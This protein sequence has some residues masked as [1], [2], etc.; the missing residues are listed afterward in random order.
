MAIRNQYTQLFECGY[1]Q[2]IAFHKDKT[3]HGT[4]KSLKQGRFEEKE[5]DPSET[6]N[7]L[8]INEHFNGNCQSKR[9]GE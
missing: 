4:P 3:N 5:D 6:P 9:Q 8:D 2:D 1:Y 7:K